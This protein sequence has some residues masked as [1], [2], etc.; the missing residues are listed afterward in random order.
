VRFV[1]G[2]SSRR[3]FAPL[4]TFVMFR[5]IYPAP[6]FRVVTRRTPRWP[7]ALKLRHLPACLLPL[8][9]LAPAAWLNR[10]QSRPLWWPVSLAQWWKPR[11]ANFTPSQQ[12]E[13]CDVLVVGGTP[14]GVA[15]ALAAA[16]RGATVILL[17]PRPKLGGD[18]VYAML[19]MF[20][21]PARPGHASPVHGIFAEWYDQLGMAFDPERARRIFDATLA[22]EP[23]IRVL[24]DTRVL[25]ILK[26]DGRVTG[27]RVRQHLASATRDRDI[28]ARIFIDADDN[29][30]FAARAGANCY[31]GREV[32]NRDKKMQ[33]AS[34][35]FSVSG[36]D[37]NAV[38]FYVRGKRPMRSA[39]STVE[40]TASGK[41][42]SENSRATKN[43]IWLRLGG[44]HGNYA[45]E[46]GDIAKRYVPRSP[47]AMLLSIN[48]GRQSDGTVVLN[49][50]NLLNVNG[51]DASSTARAMQT[52]RAE[53]PRLVNF[54]RRAM[55]GFRNARLARIAP[56]LYIRETRHVQGFY[57]LKTADIRKEERFFDRVA[58]ASYPLDLHPYVKGQLNPFGPRRYDYTLPL[59]ALVPRDVDNVLVAS[60][61]LS[62]TYS[63]AGS[64]RVIPVT[65][66][67]GEAA[68]A[69][70]WVCVRDAVTPHDLINDSRRMRLVQSSLR[71]LGADIGDEDGP[72]PPDQTAE[73]TEEPAQ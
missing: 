40:N 1:R 43:P 29:A 17:E 63:A 21:V 52:G 39:E 23:N 59:R 7:A 11:S 26:N 4:C 2:F 34:L 70:A 68:G 3:I 45:W 32:A 38:R 67:A 27:A 44:I 9:V 61:S 41:Q 50:L 54:L 24:R 71:A 64:A 51:L 28:T 8:L 48:F 46:R 60:R 30:S 36:V 66:A 62:A 53:L 16:R 72:R 33:S 14:S 12:V 18:I 22:A 73:E 69:A 42:T 31:L 10:P 6:A 13:Q 49:T 35:L 65:V 15:A 55:P 56:E 37:W 19:N 25:D 20:D 47:D 5:W 58:F 57:A